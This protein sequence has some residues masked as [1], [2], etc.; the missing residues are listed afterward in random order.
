MSVRAVGVQVDV[1]P[2]IG[3]DEDLSPRELNSKSFPDLV[4]Q[5]FSSK[6]QEHQKLL[7]RVKSYLDLFPSLLPLVHKIYTKVAPHLQAQETLLVGCGEKQFQVVKSLFELHGDALSSAISGGHFAES[8]GNIFNFEGL[9]AKVIP[10]LEH[11]FKT[12]KLGDIPSSCIFPM[13]R[14]AECYRIEAIFDRC[15]FLLNHAHAGIEWVRE[16]SFTYA[17]HIR[18]LDQWCST[19]PRQ[20]IRTLYLELSKILMFASRFVIYPELFEKY[21]KE[22]AV[23]LNSS[24]YIPIEIS[25]NP[26][27]RFYLDFINRLPTPILA[28]IEI[29]KVSSTA[30][31]GSLD[32]LEEV[33]RKMPNLR[34]FICL[35]PAFKIKKLILA[36]MES[37]PRL[38]SL[39]VAGIIIK[40]FAQKSANPLQSLRL[41]L[42][43]EG[44]LQPYLSFITAFSP[45][46]L[47]IQSYRELPDQFCLTVSDYPCVKSLVLEA[48]ITADGLTNALS[49]PRFAHFA[50]RNTF[51]T[52]TEMG[53][54]LN[55]AQC[56]DLELL[57]AFGLTDEQLLRLPK[58]P[59]ASLRLCNAPKITSKALAQ[60][61]ERLPLRRLYLRDCHQID[62][63]V[64]EAILR[65]PELEKVHLE[66]LTKVT[67]NGLKG[68][69]QSTRITTLS[70]EKMP[71]VTKEALST[72]GSMDILCDLTLKDCSKLNYQ[73]IA[74]LPA[75]E[76][77]RDVWVTGTEMP[78]KAGKRPNYFLLHQ[79]P[80]T[81]KVDP[82]IP[83]D[84]EPI[85]PVSPRRLVH[86]PG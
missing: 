19:E 5:L 21:P 4:Y 72:I 8:I 25:V 46:H 51:D 23:I 13:L 37:C 38:E 69:F 42:P 24:P 7:S 29:L 39:E 1:L 14:F 33:I 20:D 57:N 78:L 60:C 68:L 18:S 64:I 28:R 82:L 74:D 77:L 31:E 17:L 27:K 61:I 12:G 9:P 45:A 44:N 62:D 58:L 55:L 22:I 16:E 75:P 26:L 70:L 6:P 3:D 52:G 86:F 49:R 63:K 15:L 56:T 67:V 36:V 2:L 30:L 80:R 40:G 32:H 11:Y 34:I 85:L 76:T 43:K 41:H 84:I 50:T 83:K 66:N 48:N 35:A 71:A 73:D 65:H 59:I 81:L 53:Q 10:I 54:I 79:K 47:H